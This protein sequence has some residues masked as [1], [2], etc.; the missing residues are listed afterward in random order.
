MWAGHT[1]AQL[2]SMAAVLG[3]AGWA[4]DSLRQFIAHWTMP[5][6]LHVNADWRNSGVSLF[7]PK[8]GREQ[9][10]TRTRAPFTME[11][12]NA[13]SAGIGDMLVQGW[14]DRVRVFPA[15]PEHWREAAFFDLVAEGG[16]KVSAVR[17]L[18]RV[19][20][21]RV[22]ATVARRLVLADPFDGARPVLPKNI[23]IFQA[24]AYHAD[25]E[26]GAALILC[27]RGYRFDARRAADSIRAGAAA[28]PGLPPE[29][30]PSGPVIVSLSD[31]AQNGG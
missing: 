25:L 22:V 23:A 8:F 18:G 6:G 13:V 26:A 15:V 21:V 24:G 7:S 30:D 4:Y 2:I 29:S 17:R 20:W 14:R 3:R 27:R 1:Y 19:V 9:Y 16:W 31:A 28:L 11:A 10:R 5:N 12:N